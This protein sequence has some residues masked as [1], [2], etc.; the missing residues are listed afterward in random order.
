MAAPVPAPAFKWN[1]QPEI[2]GW[3]YQCWIDGLNP[4]AECPVKPCEL[5]FGELNIEEST[6][7]DD[8]SKDP[9]T[10]E[11]IPEVYLEMIRV[12]G[13]SDHTADPGRRVMSYDAPGILF[14]DAAEAAAAGEFHRAYALGWAGCVTDQFIILEMLNHSAGKPFMS[15]VTNAVYHNFYPD[16]DPEFIFVYYI[17]N[18]GFLDILNYQIYTIVNGYDAAGPG[19]IPVIEWKHNTPEYM[20]L[21]GTPIGKVVAAFLLGRYPPGTVQI[22]SISVRLRVIH[23]GDIHVADAKF[24]LVPAIPLAGDP[25]DIEDE[26]ECKGKGKRKRDD[27]AEPAAEAGPAPKDGGP[28]AKRPRGPG[29]NRG[30]GSRRD[31]IASRATAVRMSLPKRTTRSGKDYSPDA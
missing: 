10:G 3:L 12:F 29:H 8:L 14:P 26:G 15:E 18:D 22:T 6:L 25:M 23:E 11:Y 2:D 1:V 31:A 4:G 13:I 21:L 28:V 5:T 9:T 27:E 30:P 24:K 20:A 16:S 7:D 19:E 17:V